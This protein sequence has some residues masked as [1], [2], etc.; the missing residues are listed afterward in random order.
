MPKD[1]EE[2]EYPIR[3][4]TLPCLCPGLTPPSHGSVLAW[5]PA[6]IQQQ[7]EQPEKAG[8]QDY[9]NFIFSSPPPS[10]YLPCPFPSSGGDPEKGSRLSLNYDS[11]SS[12]KAGYTQGMLDALSLQMTG[13][14]SQLSFS[15]VSRHFLGHFHMPKDLW[16]H[17]LEN[18]G[19]IYSTKKLFNGMVYSEHSFFDKD[20]TFLT[21]T[22]CNGKDNW[23]QK[24]NGL[25]VEF[26]K[27]KGVTYRFIFREEKQSLSLIF[28]YCFVV[29]MPDQAGHRS[30]PM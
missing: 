7:D 29:S 20:A 2:T 12:F 1:C 22:F 5:Y 21:E 4:N 30:F 18:K 15:S 24:K 17:T 27:R 13:K 19:D 25:L 28:D 10:Q 8:V 26:V 3:H 6:W 11:T 16:S 14:L 9:G 23:R